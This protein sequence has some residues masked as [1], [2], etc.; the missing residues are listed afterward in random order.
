MPN[1]DITHPIPDLTGY[2][3]E[4]QIYIDRQLQNRQVRKYFDYIWF[5]NNLSYLDLS[6]NKCIAFTIQIDEICYWRRNDK[7]RS[8]WCLESIVCLL[9][10]W[11]GTTGWVQYMFW[12]FQSGD[13]GNE[14][15]CWR[16]GAFSRRPVISRIFGE[17]WEKFY[18][19]RS[20][21]K[22]IHFWIS[23]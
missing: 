11:K 1:E 17:I 20:Q 8:F 21:W 9:R 14:S 22:P 4:G 3:T 19:S 2:I 5:E 10:Y 18:Q 16:G 13:L 12:I 15:C 6:T 23:W 7:G